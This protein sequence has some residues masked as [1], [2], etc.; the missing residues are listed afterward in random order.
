MKSISFIYDSNNDRIIVDAV[1]E[2]G[3]RFNGVASITEPKSENPG[4]CIPKPLGANA[5]ATIV[6]GL[7]IWRQSP[8]ST[9]VFTY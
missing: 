2:C 1:A 4:I 5:T 7:N 3:R 8:T 6:L 9:A